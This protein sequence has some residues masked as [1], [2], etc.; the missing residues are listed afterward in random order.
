MHLTPHPL[1]KAPVRAV[2]S[3]LLVLAGCLALVTGSWLTPLTD[4][5]VRATAAWTPVTGATFNQPL[6]TP[7]QQQ[8]VHALV[9][10]TIDAA[11]RGSAIRVAVFSF[12]EKSTADALLRARDRGVAVRVIFDDHTIYEQEARLRRLI[13]S[14]PDARS[15]VLFCSHA[16]RGTTGDMHDKIF[17]FSRAGSA[18]DVTMVGSNNMT[19]FNAQHQ[20]ADVYTAANNATIY[21]AYSQLFGRLKKARLQAAYA[22]TSGYYETGHNRWRASFFPLGPTSPAADPVMRTL[23]Q[24]GCTAGRGAGVDGHTKVRI[25]QHAWFG[26]RGRYIAA[27]VAALS[28]AGCVVQ[29]IP[30]ISV[31]QGVRDTLK[32]AGVALATVRHRSARTHQKVLTISGGYA[33]SRTAQ[34]VFTGSHNYT[35]HALGCDDTIF[36]VKGAAAYAQYS[37]NFEDIWQHG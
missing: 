22:R 14:D 4:P 30:G 3:G 34:V 2:L 8:R 23:S 24:I 16:C 7:E 26:D 17:T 9:N 29:V 33:G 1:V 31:G 25:S 10:R 12:S 11:P 18:R 19:S 21:D 5:A 32:Q 13:G 28:R 35:D 15:F 6:G 20:W 36:M 37:A 27:K